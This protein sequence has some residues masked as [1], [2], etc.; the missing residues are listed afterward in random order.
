MNGPKTLMVNLQAAKYYLLVSSF[1]LAPITWRR[2]IQHSNTKPNDIQ[3]SDTS[4]ALINKDSRA[5]N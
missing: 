3:Q 4:T 1:F 2:D 5:G